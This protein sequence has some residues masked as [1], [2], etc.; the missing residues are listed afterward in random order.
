MTPTERNSGCCGRCKGTHNRSGIVGRHPRI[1]NFIFMNG[2]SGHGMQQGPAIGRG[3]AELIVQ[4][5]YS[6]VD[7]SALSYERIGL[8]QPLWE[9]NVIG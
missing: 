2:F 9:L 7:L 6:S 1:A 5:R 4:G 8:N 3:V